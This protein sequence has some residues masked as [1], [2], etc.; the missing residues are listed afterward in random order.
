MKIFEMN[1]IFQL[2]EP[3]IDP[4]LLKFH[5]PDVKEI[6][7]ANGIH[8][9]VV[10]RK[11]L[12]KVY[13]RL[14]LNIGSKNDP[15]N[16]AGLVQL[17]ANTLKKGTESRSY[18]EIIQTIEQIGGDLDTTVNEDFLVIHGEFLKD[19]I[20]TGMEVISDLIL[21]PSFPQDEIEK[22]RYKLIADL[23][24]EK[25]S[26]D[27]LAQ[28]RFE[29]AIFTP[30]PYGLYKTQ[31]SLQ[32]MSR[33]DLLSIHQK[34]F[35]AQDAFLV[36][37][38][39]ITE[40][41]AQ[42]LATEFLGQW[43]PKSPDQAELN[44]PVNLTRSQIQLVH[45]PASEQTHILIGN[46]LF[47]RN[48]PEFVKMMV[49]NKI[50]G[51][52]GSGRLFMNLREEKGYTYG[53]YSSLLTRKDSGAFMANAEVRTDVTLPAIEAFHEE[54]SKIKNEKVDS[55]ELKN[56]KRFLRGIFPLQNETPSSIASLALKEKLFEL[57]ED[58]WNHYLG[59]LGEVTATDV[60]ETASI[61]L[62]DTADV[63]VI[64][65]DAD[66]LLPSLEPLGEI[67]VYD[68]EDKKVS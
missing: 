24:N 33:T 35:G 6:Q 46:I 34:F 56:A 65:G 58:Y 4:T 66:R 3:P 1:K 51:G 52:G 17:F 55:N 14:G 26:P 12:P 40:T 19:Y 5:F 61:F 16:R 48:H 53:A 28:R 21:H 23:E 47:P 41:E 45:R 38:G 20:R 36:M 25:S 11:E 31:A 42:K 8:L 57:G 32:E 44:P 37:A 22:E 63:T 50:L 67:S 18:A 39:D 30:H 60:R 68:L 59:E 62:Q 15:S 2:A 7:L 29:K 13:L 43:N 54:F 64:V 10:E 49:M 27:F 9:L